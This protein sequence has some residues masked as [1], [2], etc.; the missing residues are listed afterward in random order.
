MGAAAGTGT[1]IKKCP[2]RD[3][4][5]HYADPRNAAAIGA[6]CLLGSI[7]GIQGDLAVPDLERGSQCLSMSGIGETA[8]YR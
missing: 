4:H 1:A 3:L 7:A 6:E 2:W 8:A 5:S